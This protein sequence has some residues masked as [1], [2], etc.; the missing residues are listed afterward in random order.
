MDRGIIQYIQEMPFYP[1]TFPANEADGLVLEDLQLQKLI[2]LNNGTIR[3]TNN[4][5]LSLK[6]EEIKKLIEL[7][8]YNKEDFIKVIRLTYGFENDK[9]KKNPSI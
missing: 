5:I 7:Y 3:I 8:N 2:D 6:Y 4:P 1:V 9:F